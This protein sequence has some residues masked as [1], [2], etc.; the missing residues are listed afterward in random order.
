MYKAFEQ[1]ESEYLFM[2]TGTPMQNKLDELYAL[3]RL[4]DKDILG[5]VTKFKKEHYVVG[6]KFGR[7]FMELGYKK[8]DAVREKT[9]PFIMRRTKK[10][11]APDL[12]ERVYSKVHVDMYGPQEDLYKEIEGNFKL[13]QEEINEFYESQSEH[14]AK[15]GKKAKNEDMI[16]GY[17][18]MLQAV[19]NHPMQLAKSESKMAKAYMPFIREARNSAKLDELIDILGPLMEEESKVI[20]FSQYTSMLE[21]IYNHIFTHFG[22]YPYVIHGGVAAKDRTRF[23]NEFSEH[24]LRNIMLLSDAGNYGLIQ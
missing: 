23:V 13:L 20:I 14:D 3:F 6:E 7:R 21:I 22:F 1:L 24:P 5:G 11:V 17:L 19:S 8:L 16:L 18:Y 15:E 2:L 4:I 12:P 9:A 10:E